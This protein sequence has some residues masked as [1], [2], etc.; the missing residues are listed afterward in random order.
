[1]E[2]EITWNNDGHSISL[3]LEKNLLVITGV[4]CPHLESDSKPC[5]LTDDGCIVK[6][7][8]LV[9]GLEC[10]VGVVDPSPEIGIAW[11]LVGNPNEGLNACQVWVIPTED[12][13]FSAWVVTQNTPD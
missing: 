5:H 7:F 6:W 10:N 13:F 3:R 1:M 4:H 8:L 12:E 11:S 9:Y 2:Q